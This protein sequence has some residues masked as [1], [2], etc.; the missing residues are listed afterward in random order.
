MFALAEADA[1]IRWEL[2]QLPAFDAQLAPGPFTTLVGFLPEAFAADL[3]EFIA[4]FPTLAEHYC[5]PPT[6]M[7][8]TV[9]NLDRADLAELPVLL[10]GVEPIR[11]RAIGLGFTRETLL[12][13]MLAADRTLRRLRIR[14][15]GLR[16]IGPGRLARRDLAFANVLRL[17]GPVAGELRRAVSVRRQIFA[18]R[19]LE[20]D[21]LTLIRTDKVGSPARSEVLDQY[22]LA[23][24]P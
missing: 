2:G 12:L 1:R 14:L 9:R 11:L 10:E 3:A 13:R 24:V 18:G 7:H 17:N 19:V 21:R 8:V 15:D 22:S 16:G 4:A 5:Y 6:Q 20:L 23:A